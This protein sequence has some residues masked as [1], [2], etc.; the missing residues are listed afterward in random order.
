MIDTEM[1]NSVQCDSAGWRHEGHLV[2][3]T[4]Q[5]CTKT[6]CVSACNLLNCKYCLD[7]I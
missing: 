4:L 6:V 2:C 7:C 5:V 1:V 3:K